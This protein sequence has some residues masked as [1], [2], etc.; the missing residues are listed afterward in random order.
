MIRVPLNTPVVTVNHNYIGKL[1]I[2]SYVSFFIIIGTS[3]YIVVW[4]HINRNSKVVLDSQPFFLNIIFVGTLSMGLRILPLSISMDEGTYNN[5]TCDNSCKVISLTF[6]LGF[7]IMFSNLFRK[8]RRINRMFQGANKMKR[9][10]VTVK[11]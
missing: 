8:L 10:V 6:Y 7:V 1:V 4:T 3:F 11:M 2:H 9:V 5:S